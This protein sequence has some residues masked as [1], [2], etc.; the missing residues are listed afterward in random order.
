MTMVYIILAVFAVVWT[1]IAVAQSG[2]ITRLR[3]EL[4]CHRRYASQQYGTSRERAND[5]LKLVKQLAE[6]QGYTVKIETEHTI[7]PFAPLFRKPMHQCEQKLTL[8]KVKKLKVTGSA[9]TPKG[10]KKRAR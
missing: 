3:N 8:E 2:R 6:T 9:S 1:L 10:K 4:E 7:N 5:L